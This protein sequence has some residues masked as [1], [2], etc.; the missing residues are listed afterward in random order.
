VIS[1]RVILWQAL[2]GLILPV[3]GGVIVAAGLLL[4]AMGDAAGARVCRAIALG[5]GI[6]WVIDLVVL[7]LSLGFR[8]AGL[9]PGPSEVD[10]H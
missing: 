7:L 4:G 8:A 1:Q 3:A 5:V 9:G 6:V 10:D 2:L